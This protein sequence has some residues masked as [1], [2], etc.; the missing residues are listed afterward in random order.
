[1]DATIWNRVKDIH[2]DAL[3]REPS[4]RADF[5][6]AA[7][8]PDVDLRRQV[9]SLLVADAEAGDFL[10]DSKRDESG[11]ASQF[12]RAIPGD[13]DGLIEKPGTRIGRYALHELLGEG[14]FGTVYRAEQIEPVRRTVALK[15]IKPGMDSRRVVA[16]FEA[17]RQALAMMDHPGIARVFDGGATEAGRPYFV[18]ELV[19]GVP[20]TRFCEQHQ[21][22]LH[23]RLQLFIRI[24]Q[25]VQHAHQ[26]GIIH[27]DLKPSNVLVAAAHGDITPKVIDF[28]VAKALHTRLTEQTLTDARHLV[29]TPAYMSPEQVETGLDIDTRA[30][31]YSLGVLLYELLTGTPPFDSQRLLS[32][33]YTEMLR[34]IREVDPPRP[35]A[36]RAALRGDLD[37]IVMKALEK[38]RERRYASVSALAEDVQR[39]FHDEP[40][41]AGPPT[42]TYRMT[43]FVRRHRG[44]IGASGASLGALL[45]GL[46]FAV[47]AYLQTRAERDAAAEARTSAERSREQT[48]AVNQF[49]E[50]MLTS[51]DTAQ[52]EG[53]ALTVREV[54]DDAATRLKGEEI[55]HPEVE[56]ALRRT[57]GRTYSMV[58]EYEQ[59]TPHLE[60]ALELHTQQL[61]GTQA[62]E[63]VRARL[64]LA[65]NLLQ[66]GQRDRCEELLA[67]SLVRL[68]AGQ[69][70]HPE[71]LA[72]HLYTL[73]R[74]RKMQNDL[75]AA[76]EHLR[77]AVGL[78]RKHV[79]DSGPLARAMGE[80]G[81]VL[82]RKSDFTQSEEI[83]R[84]AI[85][86]MQPA[87]G[88]QSA[89]AAGLLGHL[90]IL[91]RRTGRF[92]EAEAM[93]REVLDVQRTL[94][95]PRHPS[96][97]GTTVNLSV[98]LLDRRTYADA[99]ALLNEACESLRELHGPDSY[100]YAVALGLLGRALRG[101]ERF[102]AAEQTLCSSLEA[103]ERSV[104]PKHEYVATS[105]LDLGA[106]QLQR[107]DFEAAEV[108][109]RRALQIYERIHGDG[110]PLVANALEKLGEV[111][112]KRG[113]HSAG[114]A[115]FARALDLYAAKLGEG[116][117]ALANCRSAWA[118][119]EAEVGN[120]A[121]AERLL[122]TAVEIRQKSRTDDRSALLNDQVQLGRCLTAQRRFEE[123]ELLL[124]D[125][126][127]RLNQLPDARPRDVQT[128]VHELVRLYEALGR[129]DQ[130][131][132][133]RVRLHSKS[134]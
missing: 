118:R 56:A 90:A 48:I 114:A 59:A 86:L 36:R 130:T 17:E 108:S 42:A 80:L 11:R 33:G 89:D 110:H 4:E 61:D 75:P 102:D 46:G 43:K 3:E 25:A 37:W 1:M 109:F 125:A 117:L 7:C 58:G 65:D 107:G 99:E 133:W 84:E 73:G 113:D 120:A 111:A 124:I 101:Q 76:A 87:H 18:M 53:R 27:R 119:Q 78:F 32:V 121:E 70:Q 41:L 63:T 104:G 126:F 15:V 52:T 39:H 105:L 62:A 26:K 6:A 38:D 8:G 45:L 97:V 91:Y 44:L 134:P 100:Q 69:P 123:A 93:Y 115:Y 68:R 72:R 92:P 50:D 28:G 71:L 16:R 82:M 30:D 103:F 24:C 66:V 74:L 132:T 60:R 40:V 98:V 54:L 127:E 129:P 116:D 47:A 20:I 55:T 14:G 106:L 57:I 131:A 77:E 9:E 128:A 5:L 12:L 88:R 96:T 112:F 95:G 51:A 83:L 81:V 2:A 64:H 49:L 35:S 22:P 85:E 29:G 10:G 79:A 31:V 122:R 23:D 67:E 21:L 34:I 19:A 13:T 94:H